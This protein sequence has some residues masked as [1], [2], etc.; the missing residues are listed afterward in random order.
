MVVRS[1][2]TQPRF[3]L[4]TRASSCVT[5]AAQCWKR[6][7]STVIATG[8]HENASPIHVPQPAAIVIKFES[9]DSVS[10]H[11]FTSNSLHSI[12]FIAT[13]TYGLYGYA[14]SDFG[15][16]WTVA[17]ID[18]EQARQGVVEHVSRDAEG[19]I[20]SADSDEPHGLST[21]DF[22]EFVGV[23]GMTEL[24]RGAP[25]AAAGSAA[26]NAAAAAAAVGST[27]ANTFE[28]ERISGEQHKFRLK[29]VFWKSTRILIV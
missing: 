29:C 6:S 22:V 14:F 25:S 4:H 9:V 21:G 2:P 17:D 27:G 16:S 11:T 28:V 12:C 8:K 10:H 5:R 7:A 24:N 19:A 15:P 1:R 26:C 13:G 20:V 23:E 18:G 3:C